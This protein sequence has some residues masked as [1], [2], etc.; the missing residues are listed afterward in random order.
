MY[1]TT[2]FGKRIRT[3]K[4]KEWFALAEEIIANT[5]REQGWETTKGIKVVVDVMTY[6]KDRRRRDVNNSSKALFDALEHAGVYDD[7]CHALPRFID[8]DIDRDN[9]RVE[10]VIHKFDQEK[11]GWKY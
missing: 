9:P 6:W 4:A 3:A 2:K 11:D 1:F 10:C 7:D 5:M 8:Y